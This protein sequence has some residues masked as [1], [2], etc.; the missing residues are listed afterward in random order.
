M[1]L[2]KNTIGIMFPDQYSEVFNSLITEK[3]LDRLILKSCENY[4]HHYQDDNMELPYH[5]R[6]H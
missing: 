4:S 5:L 2:P 1:E 6:S 3:E